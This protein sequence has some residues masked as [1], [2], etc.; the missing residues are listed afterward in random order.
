M[1]PHTPKWAPTLGIGVPMDF[2]IFRGLFRGQNSLDWRVPYIIENLLERRCLKWAWMTNL[3]TSN[4]S[5]GQKKG[6][7]SNCQFDSR[8]LK[9]ENR[10]DFLACRWRATYHWKAL[11]E[12]Y[13]FSLDLIS[14]G[15]IH[16]KL[17]TPKVVR[18][19]TLGISW[20]SLGSPET[21]WHLGASPWP[22]TK[23]II[24]GKVVASPKSKPWWVLWIHVCPWLVRAPK[25]SSYALTNLLFGLCRFVWVSDLLANLPSPIPKLQHALLP[26]KCY[27]PR[28]A[29]QLLFLPLSSSLDS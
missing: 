17:W 6:R 22:G 26:P 4:T 19:L 29:P 21:K 14:I 2:Q 15:G 12:G 28:S 16:T 11:H 8:P 18:V 1:N 25:G 10:P 3:D 13:N 5:Y 7:K 23:Y 20:L 24:R 27:E 9:V